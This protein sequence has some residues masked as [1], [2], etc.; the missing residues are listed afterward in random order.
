MLLIHGLDF[1]KVVYSPLT[2]N[3]DESSGCRVL[4]VLSRPPSPPYQAPYGP[5]TIN[6]LVFTAPVEPQP[7]PLEADFSATDGRNC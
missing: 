6:F 4:G 2:P 1:L 7:Q 5:C 3:L